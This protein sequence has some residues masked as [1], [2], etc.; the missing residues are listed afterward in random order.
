[1]VYDLVLCL[2]NV[3]KC[4]KIVGTLIKNVFDLYYI[5]YNFH[6]NLRNKSTIITTNFCLMTAISN[7]S[8]LIYLNRLLSDNTRYIISNVLRFSVLSST[9]WILIMTAYFLNKIYCFFAWKFKRVIMVC[10]IIVYSKF[11]IVSFFIN[12]RA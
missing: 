12:F 9:F 10:H 11:N 3:Q 2:R 4:L 7:I 1:M 8:L 6:R 5:L